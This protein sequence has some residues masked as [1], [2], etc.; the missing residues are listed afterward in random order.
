MLKE[1]RRLWKEG[2]I[3]PDVVQRLAGM[4]AD[5][6]Y[7]YGHAW[8]VCTGRAV[9]E[10]IRSDLKE[11]DK[12]VNR[13]ERA[14]RRMVLEHL[15]LNPGSDISGCLAVMVMAK[16]IERIGDHGRNIYGLACRLPKPLNDYRL[17][18]PFD[19]LQR[20][21]AGHFPLLERAILDSDEALSRRLLGSYQEVKHMA[22]ALQDAL[23]ET[24]MPSREAVVCALLS[25][26]HTRINAH[27]G[28]AAS[29]IIFPLEN[30]D[31]VSR[32]LRKQP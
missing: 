20:R 1:L 2:G 22:K 3:L 29:G 8:E 25:R 9:A 32:G 21:I 27:I 6:S 30:I 14:V 18:A 4:V 12:A 11:R 13:G 5:T 15:T 26:F 7:V 31:F 23:F 16:D 24:E 17:F 28:N 19:E 10:A